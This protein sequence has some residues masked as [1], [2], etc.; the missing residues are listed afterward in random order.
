MTSRITQDVIVLV[1]H[2]TT[3]LQR[4]TTYRMDTTHGNWVPLQGRMMAVMHPPV[5]AG[6]REVIAEMGDRT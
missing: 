1:Q 5:L 3:I 6:L 4:A 2:T